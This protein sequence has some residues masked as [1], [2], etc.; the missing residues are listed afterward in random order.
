MLWEEIKG[1]A[2]Q[3]FASA[4]E[5]L[6]VRVFKHTKETCM[7]DS[8]VLEN[9]RPAEILPAWIERDIER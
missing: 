5:R 3:H 7:R 1:V 8:Q 9:V 6:K 2:G 4:L